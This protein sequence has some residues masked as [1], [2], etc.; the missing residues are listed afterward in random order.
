MVRR[1]LFVVSVKS[2]A[3]DQLFSRLV[4]ERVNWTCEKCNVNFAHDKHSLQ[5]SH[6]V[7]RRVLLLRHDPRNA[8]ALCA[9]CHHYFTDR[10]LE[11]SGWVRSHIGDTIADELQRLSQVVHK[12][13]KD[14]KKEARAHY[15]EEWKKMEQKRLDGDTGYLEFTG[16][17]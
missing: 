6:I 15:R 9:S 8:N 16:Y 5:C 4:R 13:H 10:P 7:G 12:R 14:W 17:W 1:D 2:D 3:L 11:F